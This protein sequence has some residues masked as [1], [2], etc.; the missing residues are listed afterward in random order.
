MNT[1]IILVI[2]TK[3]YN[4][5]KNQVDLEYMLPYFFFRTSFLLF[6]VEWRRGVYAPY[7]PPPLNEW[8]TRK[9]GAYARKA[10]VVP[11]RITSRRGGGA[12]ARSSLISAER[13]THLCFAVAFSRLIKVI[14]HLNLIGPVIGSFTRASGSV[15]RAHRAPV[16]SHSLFALANSF[17]GPPA[18]PTPPH[19]ASPPLVE[20]PVSSV[21]VHD[22][23]GDDALVLVAPRRACAIRTWRG[24]V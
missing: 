20:C 11:R 14:A 8:L 6:S 13:K 17:T 10:R 21:P 15:V 24:K 1:I 19:R 5:N 3:Q 12:K 18:R 22:D 16:R 23:D 4:Y 2:F 7:A 9:S